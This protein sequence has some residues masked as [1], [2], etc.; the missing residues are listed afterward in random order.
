MKYRFAFALGALVFAFSAAG[1][2][3]PPPPPALAAAQSEAVQQQ[4]NL[5]RK[6]VDARLARGD[7]TRDKA[8]RLVDWR[9]WQLAQQQSGLA[10]RSEVLERQAQA[11]AERAAWE[12][13]IYLSQPYY[14]A[15]PPA[16]YWGP[17]ICAGG[18]RRHVHG[19]VCF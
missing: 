13:E 14:Y 1:Q 4:L 7:I 8:Q 9:A 19:T 15:P 6:E 11:D 3:P 10:P 18:W 17:V 5:Y 2:A 16:V 12:R